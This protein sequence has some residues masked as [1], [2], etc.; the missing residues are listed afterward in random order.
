[1]SVRLPKIVLRIRST[2][3]FSVR[4]E[5]PDAL[6]P[7]TPT[8]GYG[9]AGDVSELVL[10]PAVQRPARLQEGYSWNDYTI[11]EAA[12]RV[13]KTVLGRPTLL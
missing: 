3:F 1:M 4:D 10:I 2:I 5:T 13:A 9:E 8:V 12:E 6:H 11:N 7:Y